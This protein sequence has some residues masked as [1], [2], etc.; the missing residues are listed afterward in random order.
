MHTVADRHG[1]A[2]GSFTLHLTCASSC[3]LRRS[4]E[5]LLVCMMT[6]PASDGWKCEM[7]VLV[8]SSIYTVLC[9]S[10]CRLHRY[11]VHMEVEVL[12]TATLVLG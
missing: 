4:L 3:L 9:S 6:Q 8:L 2:G 10:L 5:Y 1:W 12:P 7:Q 11:G